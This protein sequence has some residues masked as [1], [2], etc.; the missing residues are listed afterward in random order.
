VRA[1]EEIIGERKCRRL[2]SGPGM[3]EF[4]DHLA[5]RSARQ[6]D[7]PPPAP[8]E[9]AAEFRRFFCVPTPVRPYVEAICERLGIVL[10]PHGNGND[11]D[12][13]V[14]FDEE[15]RCWELYVR[16]EAGSR[17][18]LCVCQEFTRRCGARVAN[19]SHGGG[20]EAS[21]RS[22]VARPHRIS[23]LPSCFRPRRLCRRPSPAA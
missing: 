7:G 17:Q 14:A 1:V 21:I 19:G 18:S 5:S 2:R 6:E 8:E 13:A 15:K 20:M 23:P 16:F 9:L 4:C 10:V 11:P 22:Y 12:A 3:A